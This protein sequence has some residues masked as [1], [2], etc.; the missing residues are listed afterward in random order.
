MYFIKVRLDRDLG[1][2]HSKVQRLMT[3]LMNFNR[4]LL[5]PSGAGWTPEADLYETEQE[6]TLVMNLAGARKTDIEVSFYK[7]YLL[8]QGRRPPRVPQGTPTR[9]HQLEIGQGEFER[10]FRIPGEVDP[11]GIEASYTDGLLTVHL[12]KKSPPSS[13]N[14]QVKSW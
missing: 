3:E 13:F 11:D 4:P 7:N 10:L 2:V 1:Q 12:P 5:S 14:V 9:Y 6:V 8:V